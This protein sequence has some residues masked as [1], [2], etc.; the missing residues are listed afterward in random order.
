L[1]IVK[2]LKIKEGVIRDDLFRTNA[3]WFGGTISSRIGSSLFTKD[4]LW[5]TV[6]QTY[7]PKICIFLRLVHFRYEHDHNIIDTS[8]HDTSREKGFN[9]W[10]CLFLQK[11][12]IPLK[13]PSRKTIGARYLCSTNLEQIDSYLFV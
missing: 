8:G 12:P 2:E 5:I 7:W 6:T 11:S 3:L 9:R 4:Y 1:N 10:D 13:E